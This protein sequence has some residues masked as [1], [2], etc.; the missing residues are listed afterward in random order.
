MPQKNRGKDARPSGRDA[1]SGARLGSR[2]GGNG[3]VPIVV[4]ASYLGPRTYWP[5]SPRSDVRPRQVSDHLPK[6][7]PL[8]VGRALPRPR[9][10]ACLPRRIPALFARNRLFAAPEGAFPHHRPA[11]ASSMAGKGGRVECGDGGVNRPESLHA[12]CGLGG[13]ASI[14]VPRQV[15]DADALL[16]RG[17]RFGRFARC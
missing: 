12:K 13:K 15:E 7:S 3:C 16:R 5:T 11:F 10:R 4:G 1:A 9:R 8:R 17:R 14:E 6:T 2:S